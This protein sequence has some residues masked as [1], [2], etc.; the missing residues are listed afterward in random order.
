MRRPPAAPAP[1]S[2]SSSRVT[3]A[4]LPRPRAQTSLFL[5]PGNLIASVADVEIV[6]IL[7]CCVAVCLRDRKSQIGGVN[8]FQMPRG[9]PDCKEPLRYGPSATQALFEHLIELGANAE[10][11]EAKVFGGASVLRNAPP[12]GG[13]GSEN[14]AAALRALA[15]LGVP[16]VASDLGGHHARKLV[17]RLASGSAW[18][19]PI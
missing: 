19:R 2:P 10:E 16:V 6:T 12:A 15:A 13:L 9:A 4:A 8:H 1:A 11:L 14:A 18:I 17:Y 3:S 5:H 7:G